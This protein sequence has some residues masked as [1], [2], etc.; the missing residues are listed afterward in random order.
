MSE[1]LS[2]VKKNE[3]SQPINSKPLMSLSI[4]C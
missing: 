1:R 4:F 3:E 2:I